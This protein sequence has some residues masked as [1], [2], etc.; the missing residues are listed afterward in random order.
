MSAKP[1]QGPVRP[2]SGFEL[3]LPG[4]ISSWPRL[5]I[6]VTNANTA[7]EDVTVASAKPAIPRLFKALYTHQAA[8]GVKLTADIKAAA[9][10]QPMSAEERQ[11]AL[12]CVLHQTLT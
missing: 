2:G 6:S 3:L 1:E 8:L 4:D 5:T 7:L 10:L 11:V 9:K 12:R